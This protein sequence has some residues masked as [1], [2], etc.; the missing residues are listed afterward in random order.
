[1]PECVTGTQNISSKKL[2]NE[3]LTTWGCSNLL[4]KSH[5]TSKASNTATHNHN[6]LVMVDA[7]SIAMW[8]IIF[9]LHT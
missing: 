3:K 9:V 1:M 4:V 8:M 2:F 7:V 5:G 6:V